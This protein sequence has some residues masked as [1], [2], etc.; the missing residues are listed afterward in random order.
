MLLR[1]QQI[2]LNARGELQVFFQST[3]FLGA[4]VTKTKA[5]QGIGGQA[6]R[7]DPLVAGLAQAV[8]AVFDAGQSLVD[9]AEQLRELRVGG[10]CRNGLLQPGATFQ[11]LL[12]NRI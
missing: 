6:L 3:L 4:E 1:G 8:G 9:F 12:A 5:Q 11:Q 2:V 10:G 7:F